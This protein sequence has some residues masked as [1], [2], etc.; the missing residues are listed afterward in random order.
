MDLNIIDW[1]CVAV[2][3]ISVLYGMYRGFI[4]GVLSLAALALSILGAF[5]F[6]SRLAEWLRGNETLVATLMYYTDAASRI[7]N[8]DMSLMTVSQVSQNVLAEILQKANLPAAFREAFLGNFERAAGGTRVSAVLSQTIVDASISVLSFLICFF[9]CYLVMLFFI[10]M[11]AYVFEFPI[12]RHLDSLIGGLFGFLR[13]YVLLVILFI[14]APLILAA[15]PI[16]PVK[17]VYEAS[18]LRHL[19]D[20]RLIFSILGIG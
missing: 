11:I 3:G 8:L 5:M 7:G 16:E 13:G 19:F 2:L 14:I 17:S 9:V 12:L 6:S 4:S 15:A 10:H 20:S 1:I 18:S